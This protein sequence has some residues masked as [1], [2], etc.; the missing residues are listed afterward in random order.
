MKTLCP[1]TKEECVDD[2]MLIITIDSLKYGEVTVCS[3]NAIA[4]EL[5]NI[6]KQNDKEKL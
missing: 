5:N 2:C 1:F 3:F 4:E 6:R